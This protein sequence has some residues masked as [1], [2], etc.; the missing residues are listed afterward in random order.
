MVE[1]SIKS[2]EP[3]KLWK[4][5][6]L[7]VCDN[8]TDE[9]QKI[10]KSQYN[11]E[12]CLMTSIE[13]NSLPRERLVND[14]DYITRMTSDFK[15]P[16]NYLHTKLCIFKYTSV[17]FVTEPNSPTA[18][19]YT[20]TS[21]ANNPYC[22]VSNTKTHGAREFSIRNSE[23]ITGNGFI[24]SGFGVTFFTNLQRELV[25][26]DTESELSVVIPVFNNGDFLVSKALPSLMN[27]ACWQRMQVI[28]VDDGST[29]RKTVEIQQFLASI[30]P[31]IQTY[32]FPMGGSGSASRPRN[33][34]ISIASCSAI[35][36]L[37]PD[38]EISAQGYD[39]LLS[40]FQQANQNAQQCDFVSGYQVKLAAHP[41]VNAQHS[42]S[43]W[44]TLI[45]NPRKEFFESGMF[46]TVS[47]QAAIISRP[48]LVTNAINFVDGAVGQ[49]TLFGWEVLLASRNPTFT[50]EAFL[51]YYSERSSSVTNLVNA[52][53]FEKSYRREIAQVDW[54][55][56]NHILRPYLARK[57]DDFLNGWYKDKLKYVPEDDLAVS[58]AYLRRI[59]QLYGKDFQ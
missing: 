40:R 21:L 54:L 49:D 50:R 44:P 47:T 48:F 14:F 16:P 4:D 28:L 59:A 13:V 24:D 1:P 2:I 55:T 33:K 15:Y 35:T 3:H 5:R 57:Y 30:F 19:T 43:P 22:T 10:L 46:P 9:L 37:D 58:K 17:D 31:N 11:V 26:N 29:D 7:V 12:T 27:N 8:A 34:G 56:Q 39:K 20:P 25:T 23:S 32:A 38:N 6:V 36:F 18:N 51:I 41:S 42:F 52:K 53:F 45:R